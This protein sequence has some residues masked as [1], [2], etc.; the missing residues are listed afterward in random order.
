MRMREY[1][2]KKW[3]LLQKNTFEGGEKIFRK[4]AFGK[5]SFSLHDNNKDDD[6]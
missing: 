3:K 4:Y 5:Y 6:V 1:L 2:K